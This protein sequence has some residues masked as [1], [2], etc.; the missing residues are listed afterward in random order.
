MQIFTARGGRHAG[1][2][3]RPSQQPVRVNSG[4]LGGAAR[5]N[6][7]SSPH[8]ALW[9]PT[10]HSL[11]QSPERQ[12]AGDVL[13]FHSVSSQAGPRGFQQFIVTKV[14][15]KPKCAFSLGYHLVQVHSCC[16]EPGRR[17]PQRDKYLIGPVSSSLSHSGEQKESGNNAKRQVHRGES[18]V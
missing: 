1:C 16:L 18:Q 2:E 12:D 13:P 14:T 4:V 17:S 8:R 7:R 5:R 9:V 11:N 10:G 6:A 15:V 3:S